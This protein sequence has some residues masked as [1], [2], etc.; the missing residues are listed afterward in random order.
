MGSSGGRRGDDMTERNISGADEGEIDYLHPDGKPKV[1]QSVP[2]K[3]SVEESL[4]DAKS[5]GKSNAEADGH[6]VCQDN[7]LSEHEV[8]VKGAVK[9]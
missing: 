4:K 1:A 2:M 3:P 5:T 7:C 6:H 9:T 8:Q